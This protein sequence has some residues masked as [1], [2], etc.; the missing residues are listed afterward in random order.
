M[1]VAHVVRQFHPMVGGLEDV[2]HNLAKRQR[3]MGMD[4][5]VVTLNRLFIDPGRT[6]PAEE[7]VDGMPVYRVPFVGTRRLFVAPRVLQKL[8]GIDIVHVHAVDFFCGF[9]G[10]TALWHRKPLVLSTHGGF[11]HT[12]YAQTLKRVLFA[13]VTRRSLRKYRRVFASSR[14]DFERFGQICGDRLKLI[15]NGVATEKFADSASRTPTP[16]L[17]ALGRFAENKGLH[18]LIDMFNLLAQQVPDCRL[19]IVGNDYDG[20]APSL[21]QHIARSRFSSQMRVHEGL[22]GDAVRRLAREC[23]FFVSAATYEGFGLTLVEA[24]AAGLTPIVNKIPAFETILRECNLGCLTDFSNPQRAAEDIANHIADISSRYE[25]ARAANLRAAERYSWEAAERQFA[26]DYEAVLGRPKRTILGVSVAA[27]S[28][29]EAVHALDGALAEGRRLHVTFANAHTLNVAA[30]TP[31]LVTALRD[32][33][34]LNDGAGVDLASRIKYGRPFDENLNGTDFVPHYLGATRRALRVYLVGGRDEVVQ[35]A[36]RR[37]IE[38]WPRHSFVGW[39]DGYFRDRAEIDDL[40]TRIRR[41]KADLVLVALGNPKQ[42]LWI[43]EHGAATGA[44]LLIG[45]GALF[46]FMSGRVPR[47]P[48]WVRQLRC[49]W[50]HRLLIEPRRLAGRY[51]AG[52]LAFIARVVRERR[53]GVP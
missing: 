25:Q 2:V 21:R 14:A 28:R 26:L 37:F 22:D 23:S 19:H 30:R 53:E 27:M 9:L 10:A 40:C 12:N 36:A 48:Q 13:T 47:A 17:L 6:L 43:A 31:R 50:V 24:L 11:F 18:R 51:L 38:L 29:S 49:E 3:V 35:A 4:A 52:N 5:C 41:A 7:N 20:L 8:A 42:E 33:L 16:T 1:R 44:G 34:V 15:E 46:D 32:F 45:V 39:R